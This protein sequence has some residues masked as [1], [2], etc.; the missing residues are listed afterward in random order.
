MA[1]SNLYLLCHGG[2]I[3]Y[4]VIAAFANESDAQ[5]MYVDLA[6]EEMYE[7]FLYYLGVDTYEFCNRDPDCGL[8][9]VEL[10]LEES[11]WANDYFIIEVPFFPLTSE[12]RAKVFDPNEL[13]VY[14]CQHCH[15][16]VEAGD[17]RDW[18]PTCG[19]R[20]K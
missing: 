4:T 8:T 7:A 17:D 1:K 11:C 2:P 6:M 9:E 15:T 10:A 19:A 5:E 16:H 14:V 13:P 3:S 20:M 18:C 12:W